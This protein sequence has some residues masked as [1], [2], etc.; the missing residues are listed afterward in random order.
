MLFI[1]KLPD[2]RSRSASEASYNLN[3]AKM[4]DSVQHSNF[5]PVINNCFLSFV[6]YN[7]YSYLPSALGV[8]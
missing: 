8:Q 4:V 1:I 5:I 7:L 3:V 6:D 2:D